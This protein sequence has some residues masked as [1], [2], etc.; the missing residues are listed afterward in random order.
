MSATQSE[1]AAR[2]RALH[3]RAGAFVIPNVWD[4]ASADRKSVV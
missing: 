2:L 1:K 3:E 4:G